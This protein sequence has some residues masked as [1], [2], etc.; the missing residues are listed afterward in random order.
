MK[1][2]AFAIAIS[3]FGGS[4]AVATLPPDCGSVFTTATIAANTTTATAPWITMP[5][6]GVLLEFSSASTSTANEDVYITNNP[7]PS[8]AGIL[9]TTGAN[10]QIQNPS[11]AAPVGFVVQGAKFFR[12]AVSSWSAGTLT[13]TYCP[14]R[15]QP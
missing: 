3:L 13:T 9:A 10:T 1:K 11:A 14:L 2:L 15:M 12:V 8:N 6:Q 4:F 7:D 5:Q